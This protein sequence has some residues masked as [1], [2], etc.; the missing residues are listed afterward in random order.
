MEQSIKIGICSLLWSN[1][2]GE[3]LIPWLEEVKELGYD[4][5]SGF[6]DWGWES[7][8]SDGLEFQRILAG[9][10]LELA[11]M[12]SGLH[13]NFDRYRKLFT[14]MQANYCENLVCLGAF[15]KGKNDFEALGKFLNYLGRE[16]RQY[17]IYVHYHNHT[18]NTGESFA[19][20]E[21]LLDV[22]DP[23]WVSVMCDVGHATK[24]F[25][26]LP[27]QDRAV[28]FM[29]TYRE[30][31]RFIE[32]KDY[33]E[34]T[35]L[36]TPLG[37]GNCNFEGVFKS[38]KALTYKGWIVVEQNGHEGKSRGREPRECAAISR[39]YIKQGLGHERVKKKVSWS[40]GIDGN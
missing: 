17:G 34:E 38:I 29:E 19:D 40:N 21:T 22:T 20:M 25:H 10:G 39:Q 33:S 24:D 2:N 3:K 36:N 37:E 5:V 27:V 11:S 4:G 18:D 7:Y 26:E 1:P 9:H 31:L 12:I 15:G 16:A 28:S 8:L 30:R 35:G 14:F 23:A 13:F 32:L 6:A